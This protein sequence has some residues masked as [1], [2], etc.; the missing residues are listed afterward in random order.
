[1]QALDGIRPHLNLEFA[2][3]SHGVDIRGTHES[4]ANGTRG[5]RARR[6]NQKR[7]GE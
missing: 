5:A 4:I 7:G 3:A 6:V 2:R 1:M